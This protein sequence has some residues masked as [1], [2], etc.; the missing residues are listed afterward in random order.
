MSLFITGTDTG[1]GKTV[2]TAL[3]AR[4]FQ[5]AGHSV[6]VY[7]PVQTGSV[8]ERPE[9]PWQVRDWLGQPEFPMACSYCFELPA[10][11]LVS[12]LGREI[13]WEKLLDDFQALKRRYD[14]VLVE[15]AGGVRV[16]ITAT[17]DMRDLMQDFG[18]PVLVVARPTLG[19]INQT[20]LTVESLRARRLPV[21]GVLVSNCPEN[22]ADPAIQTLPAVLEQWLSVP[23]LGTLP[24]F[25][26][27][28]GWL[29]ALSH[30]PPAIERM[31]S[32][33]TK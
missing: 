18:L 21:L 6:C 15:G 20:L 17:H 27:A 13:R 9:D 2:V 32:L 19:T 31:G 29:R 1:V 5:Q 28:S 7:K 30:Y 26:L 12:D 14:V 22:S 33:V 16:P 8:V 25:P 4:Y 10:A 24:P 11:P 23:Y 3:L